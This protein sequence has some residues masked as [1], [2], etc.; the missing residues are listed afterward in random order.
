MALS[1]WDACHEVQAL[2]VAADPDAGGGG[3]V[4]V[5]MI[6]CIIDRRD[7]NGL[8]HAL[9]EWLSMAD[10]GNFL[11]S[12]ELT[13]PESPH[14]RPWFRGAF[15]SLPLPLPLPLF[16]LPLCL[17]STNTTLSFSSLFA[18]NSL[19]LTLLGVAV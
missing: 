1:F 4:F 11:S 6:F 18:L 7:I 13:D 15:V 3:L 19:P 2:R 16:L 8:K 9:Y 14:Y 12:N 5:S 17:P 10:G